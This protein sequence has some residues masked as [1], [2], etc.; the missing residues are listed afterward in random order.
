MAPLDPAR[1]QAILDATLELLSEVGYDR[2][3]LDQVARRARASKATIYRRWSGKAELVVDVICERVDTGTPLA[4]DTGSL[5][6]DLVSLFE[7]LCATVERKHTLIIGLS[8]TLLS[9]EELSRTLRRHIPD[10]D[11]N[12]VSALLE[13]A[14]RRG[15]L[16]GP[17][18][19]ERVFTLAEALVWHRTIFTGADFG[20]AFVADAVD[21][22]LLPLVRE[23]SARAVG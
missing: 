5:R 12:G 18:A 21:S 1:E 11:L 23:W 8:S 16:A 15:E 2:M 22:Y 7:A 6:G 10:R 20:A 3:T 17:V 13:R 4:A 9:D 14:A 19:A